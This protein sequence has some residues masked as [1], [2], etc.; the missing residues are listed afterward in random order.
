MDLPSIL[1]PEPAGTTDRKAACSPTP[2]RRLTPLLLALALLAIAGIPAGAQ[3]PFPERNGYLANG[4]DTELSEARIQEEIASRLGE[5]YGLDGLVLMVDQCLPDPEVY[6]DEALVHY[7]LAPDGGAM[8]D[9]A[10][11]WLICFEPRFVGF[12]YTAENPY[13]PE[14]DAAGVADRASG[15]MAERLSAGNFTGGIT[16]GI[17]AVAD[18]L[19]GNAPVGA[20]E[21]PAAPVDDLPAPAARGDAAEPDRGSSDDAEGDGSLASQL[22]AAGALGLGGLW[23]WRRRKRQAERIVSKE[24]ETAATEASPRAALLA[25]LERLDGRLTEE[26]PAVARLVLAYQSIGE[27]A[28]LEVSRR[29]EGMI[30]R[31]RALRS[32]IEVLPELSAEGAPASGSLAGSETGPD[33]VSSPDERLRA[34]YAEADGQLASLEAYVDEIDAE[35]D[36]VEMLEERAA[37]LTVEARKAIEAGLDRYRDLV[38]RMDTEFAPLPEA[39]AAMDVPVRLAEEAETVLGTGD[40]ITA[41]RLAEDAAT[42]AEETPGL[43]EEALEVDDRIEEG[44]TLF[45]RL[46]AYA[47]TSWA[48][49]RGNGSEAEESLETALD[50]LRRTLEAG[51]GDFGADLAAGYMASLERAAAE[52]QRA[53]G[54]IDAI[55]QRLERLEQARSTAVDRIEGL[56]GEI[57]KARQWL[58]SPG[59]AGDVDASPE[60]ALTE[61]EQLLDAQAVAMAEAKPD[62]LSI[63]RHLHAVSSRVESALAEGRRQNDRLDAL[64]EHWTSARQAAESAIER[65]DRY[66]ARHRADAPDS[67]TGDL[68]AA[69][70]QLRLA[71]QTAQGAEGLGDAVRVERLQQAVEQAESADAEADRAYEQLAAAAAKADRER[72]YQPRPD[73]LGPTV[74]IP[75]PRRRSIFIPGPFS[76]STGPTV[77]HSNKSSWGSRPRSSSRPVARRSIRSS[78]GGR[79]SSGRRGGGKGW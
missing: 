40:R 7:D 27:E 63:T 45:E 50:M 58:A 6:L 1:D 12:F 17:D 15:A 60:V 75:V 34:R 69:R 13:A 29:H 65:L 42:L 31:L 79:S 59:V 4:T 53:R 18:V 37:V 56:R 8:Y 61:A 19:E 14:W 23:L 70:E 55:E 16:A 68:A 9:D 78:G 35:A 67:V 76:S 38:G 57:E 51:P 33:A 11:V 2:R 62:W 36:H 73:W 30:E 44:V 10:V 43:L 48:D 28:M 39:E 3:S 20:V 41:G 25:R 32:G 72:S 66:L 24:D 5:A 49:V 22:A 77:R 71:E 54:L 52:L 64:R 46:D 74:P 47:E 21:E 26:H